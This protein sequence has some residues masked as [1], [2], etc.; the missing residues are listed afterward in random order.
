MFERTLTDDG[1]VV[2]KFWMHLGKAAQKKRFKAFEK[3]PLRRWR[4][5]KEQWK[6]W[7]MY[8]RFVAAADRTI[9]RTSTDQAPWHIVEGE[10][11]R[12]RSVVVATTLRD[13][14]RRGLER[15]SQTRRSPQGRKKH[16]TSNDSVA[17]TL[18]RVSR[19][20]NVLASLDMSQRIDDKRFDTVLEEQQGR[21]HLLQRRART[22]GVSTV[23]V[24]EGWDAAGKGG[25]IRRVTGALDARDYQVIP[26]GAPTDEERA[27]HYLWR[28]W[29]HL[30]RAGRLTVFD[31][32][33]YGRVLVERVEGF[34]TQAE[35]M[36]AYGEIAHFEEQ[37]VA[38][39]IL[40]AKFWIHVT[41]DEQLRRFRDRRRT[42]HKRWK[43]TDEDWRNRARWDDYMT[44]VNEMVARTSTQIAPWTL[45]EGNDKN[46]ARIKILRTLADNLEDRFRR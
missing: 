19:E 11:E 27:R 6:H 28:F 33:W 20:Y 39:G 40:V 22:E 21:L 41:K 14:I 3:D 46:F 26:I 31:R 4:V 7:K 24:F 1:A 44:A 25:A 32:S 42:E 38:H 13:A 12:Y 30:S 36:R 37:L 17:A 16:A 18:G 8:D 5:T 29:R 10:D 45:V 9:R 23:V 35:Y 15:A 2:L 43:I 34:A